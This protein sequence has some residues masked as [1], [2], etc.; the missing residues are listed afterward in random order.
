MMSRTSSIL[1]SCLPHK[2]FCVAAESADEFFG[3][4]GIRLEWL[5]DEGLEAGKRDSEAMRRDS[6]LVVRTDGV[7]R[8]GVAMVTLFVLC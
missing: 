5:I 8:K 2:C 3:R 6:E 4:R 7:D 1:P